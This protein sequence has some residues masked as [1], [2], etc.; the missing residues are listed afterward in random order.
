MRFFYRDISGSLIVTSSQVPCD[1]TFPKIVLPVP[2]NH[3]S[4]KHG[5]HCIIDSE[6]KKRE[7]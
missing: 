2:Q 1:R 5:V 4:T 3:L 7:Q 6:I